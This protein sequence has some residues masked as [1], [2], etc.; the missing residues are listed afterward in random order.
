MRNFSKALFM[1][2][3]LI[4]ISFG[5]ERLVLLEVFTSPG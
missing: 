5:S 3:M 4:S 2:M 1:L